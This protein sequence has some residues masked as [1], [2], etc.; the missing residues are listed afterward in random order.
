[1]KNFVN[2]KLICNFIRSN[3]LSKSKFC[4]LCKISMSTL[5]RIMTGKKFFLSSLFRIAKT[6]NV[7][8]CTL[9]VR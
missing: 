6:I 2:I 5:N 8:I 7:P 9:F 3:Q 1:M 4:K